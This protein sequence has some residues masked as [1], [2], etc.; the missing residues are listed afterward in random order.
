MI[1]QQRV[2]LTAATACQ[3]PATRIISCSGDPL[4]YPALCCERPPLLH[5]SKQTR[6][7]TSVETEAGRE[8]SRELEEGREA[9]K[10]GC[11]EGERRGL[12]RTEGGGAAEG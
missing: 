3:T 9:W 2:T 11:K 8:A 1:L 12:S 5:A 4:A 6:M 7:V 10:E